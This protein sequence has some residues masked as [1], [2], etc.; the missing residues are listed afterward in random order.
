MLAAVGAFLVFSQ[1]LNVWQ[2]RSLNHV[3]CVQ[4]ARLVHSA[5]QASLLCWG[6]DPAGQSG[7]LAKVWVAVHISC[8]DPLMIV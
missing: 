8:S 3:K 2:P 1:E 5:A 6:V 7:P 4:A